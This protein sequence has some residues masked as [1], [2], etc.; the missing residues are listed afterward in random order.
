MS[1]KPSKLRLN[2]FAFPPETNA[3]FFLLVIAAVMV[4]I[5]VSEII[6]AWLTLNMP[7]K[8]FD[9]HT[10]MPE[11]DGLRLDTPSVQLSVQENQ[12]RRFAQFRASVGEL[13]LPVGLVI[14]MFALAAGI[15]RTYPARLRRRFKLQRLSQEKHPELGGE[16][17]YLAHLAGVSPIPTIELGQNARLQSGQAFGFKGDHALRLERGLY[18]VV[19]LKSR[20]VFRA[21]VLHELGHIVNQDVWRSYF[22][23]ALWT[24][25]IVLVI[26]P[27][28]TLIFGTFFHR[29]L[30]VP[31]REGTAVDLDRLLTISLP[32]TLMIYV[33][34]G[35]MLLVVFVIRADLLRIRELYADYRA[36]QWGAEASL[37]RILRQEALKERVK[38]WRKVWR[39]H[40]TAEERLLSLEEPARLFSVTLSLPL[41]VGILLAWIVGGMVVPIL[42]PAS[43]AIGEALSGWAWVVAEEAINT[44]S[45]LNLALLI[46][47][48]SIAVVPVF[49]FIPV[50]GLAYLV[51]RTVGLQI[52]RESVADAAYARRGMVK[53][54]RLWLPAALLLL[55]MELGFLISPF[56]LLSPAGAF[57][58]SREWPIN[59]SIWV[60]P[61][62]AGGAGLIWLFF[63]YARY[64]GQQALGAEAAVTPSKWAD[65]VHSLVFTCLLGFF[66]IPL[67]VT[68][69]LILLF[70]DPSDPT[71]QFFE[72]FIWISL[73]IALTVCAVGFVVTWIVTMIRRASLVH[74][75]DQ[76]SFW[77][78]LPGI[79]AATATVIVVITALIGGLAAAGIIGGSQ[80]EA[81]DLVK[82]GDTSSSQARYQE[83]LNHYQQ[84]L[85]ISQEEGDRAREGLVLNSV[86]LTYV[87]LKQYDQAFK[88]YQQ[89]LVIYQEMSNLSG[90]AMT[91]NDIG[92]AYME[93]EQYDQAL[94]YF[95]KALVIYQ[96]KGYL[97]WE[98]DNLLFIGAM[99]YA[100]EQHQEALNHY[101]QALVIYRELGNR[102]EEGVVL[103]SIGR[104]Y[105]ALGQYDQALENY[106][107]ALVI[108]REVR[109]RAGEEA[110]LANIKSLPRN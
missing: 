56:A 100:L 93:L 29:A 69:L 49:A 22:A 39:L 84:A 15:Y 70:P 2:P 55:G 20:D 67:L 51:S 104:V 57:M 4:A 68:R 52:L 37:S 71:F 23:Q 110:V 17:Q 108:Y 8:D 61:W 54:L 66:F 13:A 46:T 7:Y 1:D 10:F 88:Y 6:P 82:R 18:R 3:R 105:Q 53:Y 109:N 72:R 11:F 74:R 36:M 95:Q 40:P 64:F 30:V 5:S 44:S 78:T 58:G 97:R 62:M 50:F 91:L 86:G 41:V 102:A 12:A 63:V 106:Q 94:K 92:L 16:I 73:C 47:R 31:L 27:V 45:P 96:E 59:S 9:W 89:A 77:T 60:L 35:I 103:N 80:S 24:A 99:Y 26:V 87:R 107:Q 14:G 85:V 28:V 75:R 43:M 21:V 19:L 79:L 65:R 34:L 83:A 48:A 90:E 38:G 98:G 81:E 33:Q 101:Q 25:V 76:K 32:T 42:I